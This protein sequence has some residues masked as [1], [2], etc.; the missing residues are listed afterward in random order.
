MRRSKND[1]INNK[2][3]VEFNPGL[4]KTFLKILNPIVIK[5]EVAIFKKISNFKSMKPYYKVYIMN[6]F[7]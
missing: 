7:I 1:Q 6:N 5:I 3:I 4:I 2:Y